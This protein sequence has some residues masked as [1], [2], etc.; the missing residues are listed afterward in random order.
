MEEGLDT[1]INFK[2]LRG[3]KEMSILLGFNIIIYLL[4]ILLPLLILV[5]LLKWVHQIK[6]N[7]EIQVE[8]NN[9]IIKLLEKQN[10]KNVIE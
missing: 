2:L 10:Q 3:G 8:Q 9:K 5:F 1:R 7:S 6:V 4:L